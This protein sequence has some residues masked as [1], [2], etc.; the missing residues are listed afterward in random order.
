M[1]FIFSFG[2]S[3]G[4]QSAI[5]LYGTKGHNSQVKPVMS[6]VRNAASVNRY[7]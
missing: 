1:V 4:M 6:A 2:V 5:R 7:T 3:D